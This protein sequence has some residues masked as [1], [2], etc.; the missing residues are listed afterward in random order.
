[1]T[2]TGF[3]QRPKNILLKPIYLYLLLYQGFLSI[4]V[5][6]A[7][8]QGLPCLC[9]NIGGIPEFVSENETGWSFNP[10]SI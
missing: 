8:Q 3:A 10:K 6:E 4:A 9:S 5:V 2:I 1:V 7:M